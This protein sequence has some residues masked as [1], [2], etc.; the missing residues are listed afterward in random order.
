MARSKKSE[1]IRVWN[2][3]PHAT[4]AIQHI[5]V[6][7]IVG[8]G[9]QARVLHGE[10]QAIRQGFGSPKKAQQYGEKTLA[11]FAKQA[12]AKPKFRTWKVAP[13]RV[14]NAECPAC[15][16]QIAV[17]EGKLV[18]HTRKWLYGVQK[19]FKV[20]PNNKRYQCKGSGIPVT[21][22]AKDLGNQ[23][24]RA[25]LRRARLHRA[26]DA[27]LDVRPSKARKV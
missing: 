18:P 10:N 22:E 3:K 19:N 6:E 20:D 21:T 5:A 24:R 4:D 9:Y 2:A 8:G 7:P 17:S 1:A 23:V 16:Q 13:Q 26:L 11:K 15:G 25:R 14:E 12:E 27:I